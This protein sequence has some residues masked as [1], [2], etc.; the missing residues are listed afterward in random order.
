MTLVF[1]NKSK[2]KMCYTRLDMCWASSGEQASEKPFNI[3]QSW[4][5]QLIQ[6]PEARKNGFCLKYVKLTS[7]LYIARRFI[8]TVG[9]ESASETELLV[10]ESAVAH[11]LLRCASHKHYPASS[12][13]VGYGDSLRCKQFLKIW[14]TACMCVWA[15]ARGE[16]DH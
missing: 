14:V 16:Q 9:N 4:P 15:S 12:C 6:H 5:F 1:S 3:T 11:T 2:W 10:N 13:S 7:V 8:E